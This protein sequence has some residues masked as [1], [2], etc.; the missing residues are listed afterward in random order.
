MRFATKP[1]PGGFQPE[2]PIAPSIRLHLHRSQEEKEER[3]L[4]AQAPHWR[5]SVWRTSKSRKGLTVVEMEKEIITFFAL[6]A[7]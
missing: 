7:T 3:R 6:L 5:S 4:A 1:M 2:S